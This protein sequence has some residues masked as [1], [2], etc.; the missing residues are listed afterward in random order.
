MGVLMPMGA[1]SSPVWRVYC[2]ANPI[3]SATTSN[4]LTCRA[5]PVP[6]RW[7]SNSAARMPDRA[8]MAAPT[9]ARGGPALAGA[10]GVPVMEHAPASAWISKS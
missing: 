6:V 5:R 3:H 10:S 1:R 2:S 8:Y 9:S 4:M 7:R